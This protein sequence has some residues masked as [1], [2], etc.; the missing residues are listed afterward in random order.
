MTKPDVQPAKSR[1]PSAGAASPAARRYRGVDAA[2]RIRERRAQFIEAGLELFGT[3]GFHAVTVRELCAQAQLTE[4]YFYESFK[5]RESLFAAVYE[6]LIEQLRADFL[7]A[8]APKAPQLDEM[9]RAGLG[10]YFRGLQRDPRFARITLVDVLAV[11]GSMERR[12]QAAT[13][14]FADLIRQLT[15]SAVPA[16]LRP[17]EDAMGLIATGLIGACVNIAM[18]WIADGCQPP[19]KTVIDSTMTFFD[20]TIR[21]LTL[22]PKPKA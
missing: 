13:F 21:Q 8:A 14:G 6:S 22:P 12:A 7:R 9:A 17:R 1:T 5:D 2:A 18:R 11:S 16:T 19:V 4:R 10:V 20:A 15:L 3:K